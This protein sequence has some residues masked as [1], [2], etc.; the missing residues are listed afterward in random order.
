MKKQLEKHL[1]SL[2]P[3]SEEYQEIYQI[4]NE[5]Y[6]MTAKESHD[7]DHY[8]YA[9]LL[10]M[11]SNKGEFELVAAVGIMADQVFQM[12]YKNIPTVAGSFGLK[13]KEYHFDIHNDR[14]QYD[15]MREIIKNTVLVKAKEV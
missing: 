9:Y 14:N 4:V 15:K 2:N 3:E 10:N 11:L 12:Q 13:N 6:W 1:D 7:D 8:K 5:H